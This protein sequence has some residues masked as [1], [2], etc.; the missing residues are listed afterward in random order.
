MNI[1]DYCDK[2]NIK[3]VPINLTI[4]NGKKT[5]ENSEWFGSRKP[6]MNKVFL[7]A[8]Y[9][10]LRSLMTNGAINESDY[11]FIAIDTSIIPQLDVDV[12]TTI[13]NRLP[14]PYFKSASKA[15]GKHYF[16]PT[17]ELTGNATDYFDKNTDTHIGEYL[18][19]T[20]SFCNKNVIVHNSD[21]NPN[22]CELVKHKL[23]EI[24]S[25]KQLTTIDTPTIQTAVVIKKT[26][27]DHTEYNKSTD[28][29]YKYADLI[30][31]DYINERNTWRNIV[32]SLKD[33]PDVA[34]YL[35]KKSSKFVS[36]N[37]VM[38]L[39]NSDTNNSITIGTFF[40]YCQ[41]S[42][43]IEY[44]KLNKNNQLINS[45]C[46]IGDFQVADCIMKNFGDDFV[47]LD[48]LYIYYNG[49]WIID[50]KYSLT[51]NIINE[52]MRAYF[53]NEMSK[54]PPDDPDQKMSQIKKRAMTFES[55]ATIKSTTEAFVNRLR[56]RCDDMEFDNNPF[57]LAFK[58]GVYDFKLN[59]FRS[60]CKNDFLTMST[61]YDY[62]APNV[63]QLEKID[64]IME[65]IFP[66]IEIRESYRSILYNACIGICPE[67]FVI[68][69]GSGRNGKGVINELTAKMLGDYA[70]KG[71]AYI[72]QNKIRA[73][74]NPEIAQMHNKRMVYFTEPDESLPI[75]TATMKELTGGGSINAR[76]LYS[77]KTK[78]KINSVMIVECNKK[79]NLI[80][81]DMESEC[82]DGR[83][84]DILFESTFTGDNEK[85]SMPNH[86]P[87]NPEF[88]LESFQNEH[89][90][91]LFQYIVETK[92]TKI[93]NP[94]CV[95]ERTRE[96]TRGSDEL[97]QFMNENYEKT[98]DEAQFIKIKE[99][100]STFKLSAVYL[101]MN[102][103]EKRDMNEG[104]F[105]E[106]IIKMSAFKGMYYEQKKIH[107]ANQRN[108]LWKIKCVED[109]IDENDDC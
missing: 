69:N 23:N 62:I 9:N 48:S 1:I 39:I 61:G 18:H 11:D 87:Q 68:A 10:Q 93:Y 46:G 25:F 15:F 56:A 50:H 35:S 21:I 66:N 92:H 43:A 27:P 14:L 57:L 17:Q 24:I 108:I 107:G 95:K 81:S 26:E 58:N 5:L 86:F 20:W 59:E 37:D 51:Q 53:K 99:V 22:H 29:L 16:A 82:I 109:D 31:I 96:Y 2:Y 55:I 34:K 4:K 90:C 32:W 103:A 54:I 30:A 72:L 65:S 70:Y 63:N 45:F 71:P 38:Q 77:S 104:K 13:F 6:C 91:A 105:K 76:E 74:A 84:M 89:L 101:N 83:V 64:S 47:C 49:K 97:F 100:Y 78:T 88:K 41:K 75:Q 40:H 42:N 60:I 44:D 80:G 85:L 106:R 36:D 102:K 3:I 79:P 52:F 67:K 7:D 73:G 28:E 98:D 8:E 19:G 33:Y 12:D 94:E